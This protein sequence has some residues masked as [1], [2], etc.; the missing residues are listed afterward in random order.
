MNSKKQPTVRQINAH[1]FAGS[2]YCYIRFDGECIRI[3]RAKT[4]KGILQGHQIGGE[5]KWVEIP[6]HAS[7]ELTNY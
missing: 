7:I 2:K 1:L 5:C 3:R 6:P 4:V